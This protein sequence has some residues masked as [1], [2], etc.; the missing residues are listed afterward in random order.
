VILSLPGFFAKQF[1]SLMT[2]IGIVEVIMFKMNMDSRG[3]VQ[4]PVEN[5]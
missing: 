3:H 1:S 4:Y 2:T 5:N